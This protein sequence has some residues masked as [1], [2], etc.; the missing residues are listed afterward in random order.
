MRPL[1]SFFSLLLLPG[2]WALPQ[3]VVES[4]TGAKFKQTR[5]F[6][7]RERGRP[8]TAVGTAVRTRDGFRFYTLCLYVDLAELRA[9]AKKGPRDPES[10]GRLLIQ[11]GVSHAFVTNFYEGVAGRR[12]LEFLVENVR[13]SWPEFEPAAA[14]LKR[15]LT[16]FQEDLKRG[17][18]TEVWIDAQGHIY[19]RRG[20]REPVLARSP[21]LGHAF[22]ATYFGEAA[23]DPQFKKQLLGELA[24]ALD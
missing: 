1:A 9:K 5:T 23:M 24:L 4:A 13:K 10:L 19:G 15:F 6:L 14:D 20:T 22:T 8:V 21:K 7:D 18:T 12:R 17:D 2:A 11:G 3:D 16:F